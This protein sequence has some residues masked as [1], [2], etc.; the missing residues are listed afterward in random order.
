MAT[1]SDY[2]A[3]NRFFITGGNVGTGDKNAV[4]NEALVWTELAWIGLF[5][6]RY[7]VF[8]PSRPHNVNVLCKRVVV[9]FEMGIIA[10]DVGD[11]VEI[12]DSV[13]FAKRNMD[14]TELYEPFLYLSNL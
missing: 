1:Q 2:S 8:H 14:C 6:S 3:C 7:T 12:L 11:I 9:L 5:V 4:E 13:V 10:D